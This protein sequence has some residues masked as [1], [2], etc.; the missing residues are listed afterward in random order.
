VYSGQSIILML[1]VV[2]AFILVCGLWSLPHRPTLVL[3]LVFAILAGVHVEALSVHAY[4]WG[5]NPDT[6]PSVGFGISWVLSTLAL[7]F[8]FTAV[9]PSLAGR[10]TDP[11]ARRALLTVA[12]LVEGLVAALWV[13]AIYE[14]AGSGLDLDSDHNPLLAALMLL[15]LI[16][17]GIQPFIWSSKVR[18]GFSRR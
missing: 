12:V 13:V 7:M 3:V 15:G 9:N 5:G 4:R 10:V 17:L 14:G 6:E 18:A 11:S 2:V 16:W 8:A 1:P